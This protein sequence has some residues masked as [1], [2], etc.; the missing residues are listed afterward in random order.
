[1]I[2]PQMQNQLG[3]CLSTTTT[4]ILLLIVSSSRWENFCSQRTKCLRA[5]WIS[6]CGCG[7]HQCCGTMTR[8]LILVMLTYTRSLMQSCME[9]SPGNWSRYIMQV[10]YLNLLLQPPAGW[11]RCWSFCSVTTVSYTYWYLPCLCTEHPYISMEYFHCTD[12]SFSPQCSK[13]KHW[14]CLWASSL[15][16]PTNKKRGMMFGFVTQTLLSRIFW[17]IPTSMATSTTLRIMNLSQ[18]VSVAG[19]ILCLVTGHGAMRYIPLSALMAQG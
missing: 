1:M 19:K 16:A 17:A 10:I 18:Q 7:Q 13:T 11:K 14:V 2:S 4:G 9:T 12:D 15:R 3:T 6:S 5:M 8:H